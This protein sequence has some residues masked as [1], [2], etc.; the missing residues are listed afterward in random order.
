MGDERD[1]F[2]ATSGAL[3]GRPE[4]DTGGTWTGCGDAGDFMVSV[5][6]EMEKARRLAPGVYRIIGRHDVPYGR[7]FR[8]YDTKGRLIAYCN[9]GELADL[10]RAPK[11]SA[12]NLARLFGVPV[13]VE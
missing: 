8:Y 4:V 3:S 1:R 11:G 6:R 5:E 2:D 10:P 12:S 13:H 9:R 7:V